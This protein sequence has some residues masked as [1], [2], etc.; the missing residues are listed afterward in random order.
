MERAEETV[1]DALEVF[2]EDCPEELAHELVV[3]VRRFDTQEVL[4]VATVADA[5]EDLADYL[6]RPFEMY[7]DDDETEGYYVDL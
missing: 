3:T 1:R 6:D 5:L 4:A 2:A 7:G